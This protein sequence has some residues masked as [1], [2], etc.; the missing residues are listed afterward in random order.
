MAVKNH[1]S[2]DAVADYFRLQVNLESEMIGNLKMQKLCYLAQGWSLALRGRALF[3]DV[4]EAWAL[5]P[6]V[7]ALYRRYRRHRWHAI[8][9]ILRTDPF[10]ELSAEELQLLD[11]VWEAYGYRSARKLMD[12][13]HEQDPWKDV[14]GDTE[15]PDPCYKEIPLKS[16][17]AYFL[18]QKT[19]IPWDAKRDK[20]A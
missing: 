1:R 9:F 19:P 20:A 18:K 10:K 2:A 3:D 15:F 6:L 11:W 16:I 17:K 4:I 7:P 5:G 13:V 14:Y 12:L 8:P